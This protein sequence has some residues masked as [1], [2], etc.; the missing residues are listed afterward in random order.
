MIPLDQ[1][2]PRH[3][4]MEIFA[5]EYSG[6]LSWGIEGCLE[7]QRNG[8]GV[9]D[10]V[11][12]ATKEYEAEQDT[13]AMFL[14]EKCVRVPNARALSMDV[15]RAYKAWAEQRGESCGSAGPAHCGVW[16]TASVRSRRGT[17]RR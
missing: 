1:Q 14:D 6:I 13:F 10:E 3:E 11:V 5:R 2:K 7:W 9:P 8:L 4:V 16:R 17:S 15:Y 12:A